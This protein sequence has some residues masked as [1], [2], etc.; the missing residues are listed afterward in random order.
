MKFYKATLIAGEDTKIPVIVAIPDSSDN[1]STDPDDYEDIV[2]EIGDRISY[3][4][5]KEDKLSV[6]FPKARNT[7]KYLL[8]VPGYEEVQEVPII[9]LRGVSL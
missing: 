8:Q 9:K 6:L 5:I 2:I 7:L 4:K 3:K 1:P